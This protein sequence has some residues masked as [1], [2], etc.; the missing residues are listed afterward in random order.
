MIIEDNVLAVKPVFD[1]L[2]ILYLDRVDFHE[3]LVVLHYN[4]DIKRF[5]ILKYSFKTNHFNI[6]Q[7][8]DEKR[9]FDHID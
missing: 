1:E 4:S 3:I 9:T 7:R 5:A 8:T 2:N 6:F